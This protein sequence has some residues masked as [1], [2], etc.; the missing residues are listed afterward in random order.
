MGQR[1]SKRPCGRHRL[2]G[3]LEGHLRVL[4]EKGGE[5]LRNASEYDRDV[6]RAIRT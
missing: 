4:V 2:A 5:G 3:C 6:Y 1:K